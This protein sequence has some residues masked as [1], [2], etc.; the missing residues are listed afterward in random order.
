[1]QPLRPLEIPLAGKNLI[2]ASAGTGKTW[3]ISLLY[4]RLII[5][6]LLTVD[7]LLVVT[8]TRAA[9]DEL[10]DRIRKRLK[11]TLSVYEQVYE[12]GDAEGAEREYH[13]LLELL[14][15]NAERLQY[16]RRAL[17]SFD[18]AAVFTIHG[19]CQRVLQQ[20][21]FEVG[22]P[23]ES[24]LA[25]NE[26]DL[27]LALADQFWQQRLVAPNA[28]D[29][30]VLS[31][32]RLTPDSLLADVADFIG[33]PYLQV[34]RAEPIDA[35]DF[36]AVQST[37]HTELAELRTLWQ[38]GEA[39]IIALV[40]DA[41]RLNQQNYKPAQVAQSAAAVRGLFAGTLD[42]KGRAALE[43]FTPGMLAAKTKAKKQA[44][45][46][47]FF[48]QMEATLA[49]Y[50]LLA[51]MQDAAL[52]QL[53]HDLLDWLR[54]Q[55]PERKRQN[56]TLA[57]DDLLVNLQD[58]LLTRPTLAQQL[59]A[60]YRAALVDEFQDTD[61]VQYTVFEQIYRDSDGQVY[62]VGDPKQA[63]YSF[64]G[65][66]IYTYLRAA[67]GVGAGQ[68]YTLDRNF[69]SQPRLIQAFNQLYDP[70]RVA[71]PFRNQGRIGY[72]TVTSGGTVNGELIC[73]PTLAPLR[74]WDW[75]G[76]QAD[77]D[78]TTLDGVQRQIA[79]A[80][81]ADIAKLLLQGQ[82]GLAQIEGVAVSSGDFAVL[83]RSHRQGRM[84]KE[85]LQACGIAS[86]Q[87]SPVGIFR[88][89]EAE[90]LRI[91]LAAIAEPGKVGKV[92]QALVTELMG[93]TAQTLLDLDSDQ[94]R[95][96]RELE[97]FFRWQQLW[98]KDGFMRM[99]RDWM[100]TRQVRERL[101]AYVD[102]E[103]RLTNLLHL[104]ELIHTETRM[105]WHGMQ[106]TLRWLQQR[107]AADRT[108]EEHQ[109][110]LE[111]DENLVQIV[112]IHKSKG[113]QYKIVYCP[114]LW[115]EDSKPPK[116]WFTW[117]DT[118]HHTTCLQA[119]Q[120]GVDKAK[121]SRMEEER[122]ENLRLL[123]VALTRAQYQCTVV[124]VTG[125]I[126]RHQYASAL[127]WLLFGH[128]PDSDKVLGSKTDLEPA[129]RQQQMQAALREL[130]AQAHGNMSTEPLPVG[131]AGH[132]HSKAKPGALQWRTFQTRIP[133]I[134]RIGS[135][136][137][138]T[139]GK[140]DE[141][142]DYDFR[143][144]IELQAPPVHARQPDAFPGGTRAGVCLHKMF[145]RADF[146]LPLAG[147]RT[148]V[149]LRSLQEQGFGKEW[150]AAAETLVQQALHAPLLAGKPLCLAHVSRQHRLDELEFYFPV[151]HL[152]A[153]HLKAVL[154]HYLPKD[155]KAIRTAIN[156]L[157][158]AD[159]KGYMK[160]YIDLVFQADGLFYVVDYKSNW[161]GDQADSYA[162]ASLHQAMADAHYYLQY[163]IYCVALHRYLKLRLDNYQ[164]DTHIG[165]VLYLFLRG[166]AQ[167]G[168]QGIF[169]HKPPLELIDALDGLMEWD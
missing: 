1:M 134:Q 106:A 132:Y 87:K 52:D 47:A 73:E 58:A 93:G 113:L 18:E 136:S 55:L 148:D 28:R 45:V 66:D 59:A 63:I 17:L 80:V 119:G 76:S 102:G 152:E 54:H 64:R 12:Q 131:Q 61:P 42:D 94:Q 117:Y 86:V 83:V 105:H 101:M 107:R 122:S 79:Q 22:L 126:P 123:Y 157:G 72:E 29:A 49:Q 57:F 51:A 147:Q 143:Q 39:E 163:L 133:A 120:A 153:K 135:F 82:Q 124:V 65:A 84:I 40:S 21:A 98:Q 108:E 166:M 103:R 7:Q 167:G 142:P 10:R 4:V 2:Q 164:W 25:N 48:D 90:E 158:F 146:C 13:E 62:Y 81:A 44:P 116:G 31:Q 34:V 104:G 68:Q 169:F 67:G 155:W 70:Q 8:Y 129:A 115:K 112:T 161:L 168:Q 165:G 9:T 20:H 50:D 36:M 127:G 43:R 32:Y 53:R 144:A 140:H 46:H 23:F 145:E 38:A 160:G 151:A 30:A 56:G 130:V 118:E 97:D 6:Q 85:A 3:T 162:Q 35:A 14:P 121:A 19:F 5:E 16:L 11:A 69:R 77:G 110:R 92:R 95:L 154:L 24:E 27:Q 41:D 60:Q 78:S 111:S 149:I 109:L 137:G 114:F 75:D 33:K 89:H 156:R 88:T 26:A 138:L 159:L 128:L 141:R 71:D 96:D 15:P 139:S 91:V 99:L 125:E 74:V 37:Y 100:D 150:Q